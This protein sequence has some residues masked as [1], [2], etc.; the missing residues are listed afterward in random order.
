MRVRRAWA[1]FRMFVAEWLLGLVITIA[2]PNTPDGLLLR[3]CLRGYYKQTL[4]NI[5]GNKK[6]VRRRL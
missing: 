6:D 5:E 4:T 2:P 1:E 3:S